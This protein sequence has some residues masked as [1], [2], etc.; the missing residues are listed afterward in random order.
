MMR[1]ILFP[2]EITQLSISLL[3]EE[4]SSSVSIHA[5]TPTNIPCGLEMY[6]TATSRT[7]VHYDASPS[8]ITVRIANT[9]DEILDLDFDD[10]R[11]VINDELWRLRSDSIYGKEIVT[12]AQ[13]PVNINS[14]QNDFSISLGYSTLSKEL[15]IEGYE[16]EFQTN[17]QVTTPEIEV[18][19][20]T[21]QKTQYGNSEV[22]TS[23]IGIMNIGSSEHTVEFSNSVLERYGLLMLLVKLSWIQ[24]I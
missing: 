8:L 11:L 12:I 4:L 7:G 6:V 17:G 13:I 1:G 10:C 22:F 5:Q 21:G 9:L 3:P 19:L 20:D 23:E 15:S 2:L 24:G 14:G 16:G 18:V